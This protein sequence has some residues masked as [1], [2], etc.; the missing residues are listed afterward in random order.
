M[1]SAEQTRLRILD[2]ATTEFARH[3][4][5]GA[6]VDRVA[7]GAGV[8]KPMIYTYFGSK[9][10]LFDAV[11]EAH[12][13]AN[14]DR[15]PFTP[16]DLPGYAVRLYED[17]VADP[18]LVRLLMWKR[19][20]REPD[21]YLYPGMED[22]DDAHVRDIE[23]R[24]RA[25]ELRADLSP[26]DVWALLISMASTWAQSSL[27]AVATATDPQSVHDRRSRALA[28]AVGAMLLP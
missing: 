26:E 7:L 20:E 22:L 11:F 1:S 8:S 18:S 6:R 17:Y 4:I 13:I 19:L 23:D 9:S 24:Q 25:G 27:T 14:G 2:S 12:V 3:G 5:A 15:V 10:G 28:H 16:E 21:G